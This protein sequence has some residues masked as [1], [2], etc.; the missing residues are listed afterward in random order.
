MDTDVRIVFCDGIIFPG[1]TCSPESMSRRDKPGDD[2]FWCYDERDGADE[3]A[4]CPPFGFQR[5]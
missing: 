4:R 2:E 5:V 3:A 1:M